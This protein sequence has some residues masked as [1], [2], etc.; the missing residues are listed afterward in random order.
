MSESSH[1]STVPASRPALSLD[2]GLIRWSVVCRRWQESSWGHQPDLGA[3]LSGWFAFQIFG[4]KPEADILRDSY[5]AG[6][7]EAE[8]IC[9]RCRQIADREKP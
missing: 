5:S 9:P 3:F 6:W 2:L 8:T 7:H 4:A 1:E